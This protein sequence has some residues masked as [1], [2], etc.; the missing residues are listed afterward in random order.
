MRKLPEATVWRQTEF[1]TEE[2]IGMLRFKSCPRCKGDV[3]IDKDVY[4]WYEQCLQ[5]GYQRDLKNVG[6]V[7]P[8]SEP[9]TEKVNRAE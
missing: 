3:L 5:C 8:Q 7:R 9:E 4:G 1:K 2:V 6:K